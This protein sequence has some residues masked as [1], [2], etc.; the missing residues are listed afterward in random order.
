MRDTTLYDP[1]Q[2][3]LNALLS[4]GVF[5]NTEEPTYKCPK[6]DTIC[7]LTILTQDIS[8]PEKHLPIL[9]NE[10]F[11]TTISPYYVDVKAPP[12]RQVKS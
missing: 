4:P 5:H 7:F 8:C 10:N 2:L 3:A 1:F 12:G 9:K 6:F 11:E